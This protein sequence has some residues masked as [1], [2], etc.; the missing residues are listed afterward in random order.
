[1]MKLTDVVESRGWPWIATSVV[2]TWSLLF[3]W[4]FFV[5]YAA[6]YLRL[7]LGLGGAVYPV[8][9]TLPVLVLCTIYEHVLRSYLDGA[10]V[11]SVVTW[12]VV[13]PAALASLLL[14]IFSPT[15]S[16]SSLPRLLWQAV[17]S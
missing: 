17:G 1:M 8:L 13:V 5:V 6:G 2:Y 15:D 7:S 12:S 3:W 14:V 9:F 11:S 4:L 10:E 16:E